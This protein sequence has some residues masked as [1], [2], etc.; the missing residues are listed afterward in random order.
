[1]VVAAFANQ[2]RE[3]MLLNARSFFT[4]SLHHHGASS[5]Y[6]TQHETM[7]TRIAKIVMILQAIACVLLALVVITAFFH[8]NL[9]VSEAD[10]LD[11]SLQAGP[12]SPRRS[13]E[14]EASKEIAEWAHSVRDSH[15][16]LVVIF[17]ALAG[18][19]VIGFSGCT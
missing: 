5:Y 1:P 12:E 13:A 8:T 15:C 17:M 18:S 9:I 11:K 14:M 7:Q 16:I 10:R 6:S 3:R 4:T 19:G 2:T